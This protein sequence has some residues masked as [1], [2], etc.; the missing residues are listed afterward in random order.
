ML[1]PRP[2]HRLPTAHP[3][4]QCC[5]RIH[6]FKVEIWNQAS[7]LPKLS[8][9]V[10][11]LTSHK[12]GRSTSPHFETFLL[13]IPCRVFFFI[14]FMLYKLTVSPDCDL[15]EFDNNLFLFLPLKHD[16]VRKRLC[17][18][19]PQILLKYVRRFYIFIFSALQLKIYVFFLNLRKQL[20]QES[21]LSKKVIGSLT[22]F[23][24]L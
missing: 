3:R 16:L 10:S 7:T 8:H 23:V 4:S 9:Q 14:K 13:Q 19:M 5:R 17:H 2:R 18:V 15:Q 21:G 12:E 6:L 20:A 1:D 11:L 22:S 24:E